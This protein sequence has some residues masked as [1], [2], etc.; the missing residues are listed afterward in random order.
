MP[1]ER[2]SMRTIKEVLRLKHSAHLSHRQIA[3]SLKI[4]IGVVTKYLAAAE[5]AHL[6]WP[7]P[8]TLDDL[9]LSHAL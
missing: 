4:S 3:A 6:R 5:R 7:L 1:V 9:A 2:I 8:D